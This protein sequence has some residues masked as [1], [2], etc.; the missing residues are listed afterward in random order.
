M[1]ANISRALS[2]SFMDVVIDAA[3]K[4]F[5]LLL[6]A[7][8]AASLAKRLSAAVR[9]R[10][11]CYAFCGVVVL[12]LISITFPQWNC[13]VLPAQPAVEENALSTQ[14]RRC[15]ERWAMAEAWPIGNFVRTT[16]L[17]TQQGDRFSGLAIR[18]DAPPADD[19]PGAHLEQ[20]NADGDSVRRLTLL[21][22]VL[23]VGWGIGV[24]VF[25]APLIVGI[26]ASRGVLYELPFCQSGT[27][28]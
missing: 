4:A 13:A 10:I 17:R 11:W 7:Y 18:A 5:L 14:R 6:F 16:D 20:L 1:N 25:L 24:V 8:V 22:I 12:P 26:T 15:R 9:H 21:E 27:M 19:L 23:L 28:D 2:V 3:W